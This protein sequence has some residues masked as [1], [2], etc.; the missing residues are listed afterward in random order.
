MEKVTAFIH[1]HPLQ[2]VLLGGVAVLAVLYIMRSGSSSNSAAASQSSLNSSYYQA[3]AIQAQSGAAIQVANINASATTAQTK[4]A[5]DTSIANNSTWATA[6]TTMNA[7]NLTAATAALPYATENNLISA[8]AGVASQTTTTTSS[9]NGF[10]GIGG[11]SSTTTSSTNAAQH[12]SDYLST[13]V[14]GL[15]AG[16]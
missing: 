10:F 8:L 16:H 15:Y 5:A 4:I 9:D 1:S 11:G 12:A 14:N 13:L 3:E 2:A 6:D 7:N